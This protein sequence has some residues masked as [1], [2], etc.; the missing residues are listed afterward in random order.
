MSLLICWALLSLNLR[1]G[2]TVWATLCLLSSSAADSASLGISP[3]DCCNNS[4]APSRAPREAHHILLLCASTALQ[5][6]RCWQ[7]AGEQ[8]RQLCL[9]RGLGSATKASAP[10]TTPEE[11]QSSAQLG[12]PLP[13]AQSNPG[14]QTAS[15]SPHWEAQRKEVKKLFR[16]QQPE[17]LSL[18]RWLQVLGDF[19][20]ICTAELKPTAAPEAQLHSAA[21]CLCSGRLI[22][23]H[24]FLPSAGRAEAKL[25]LHKLK[26]GTTPALLDADPATVTAE[27]L[28]PRGTQSTGRLE[29][30]PN[31]VASPLLS[32]I[33]AAHHPA[34]IDERAKTRTQKSM[35]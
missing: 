34:F 20:C 28:P 16:A 8:W 25:F 13:A 5:P 23:H 30:C 29:N 31:P 6:D 21:L 27:L 24:S 15:L 22:S 35:L 4:S 1:A 12:L 11:P 26:P 32:A 3:A 7:K 19:C 18:Q 33:P 10:S 9:L 2:G 17:K 14:R